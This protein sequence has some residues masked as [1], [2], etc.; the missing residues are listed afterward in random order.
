[1]NLFPKKLVQRSTLIKIVS[2]IGVVGAYYLYNNSNNKEISQDK[3]DI[4][5]QHMKK[6]NN[7]QQLIIYSL[8]LSDMEDQKITNNEFD[9]ILDT[10]DTV[11]NGENDEAPAVNASNNTIEPKKT[12]SI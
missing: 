6:L 11:A 12:I 5:M 3:Y 4:I 9:D 8:I 10:I 1:M 7:Q 2:A